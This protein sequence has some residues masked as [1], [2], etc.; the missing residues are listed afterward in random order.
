V[1][2]SAAGQPETGTYAYIID[3]SPTW[4]IIAHYRDVPVAEL[5]IA[6]A[7]LIEWRP[8]YADSSARLVGRMI[9]FPTAVGPTKQGELHGSVDSFRDRIIGHAGSR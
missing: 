2:G 4:I 6:I 9:D 1:T 8:A 3:R 7:P 5:H